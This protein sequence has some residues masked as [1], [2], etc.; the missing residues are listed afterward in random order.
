M[1]S[2][3]TIT[4]VFAKFLSA[5]FLSTLLISTPGYA[6]GGWVEYKNMDDFFSINLPGDVEPTTEEISYP[7]EYDA[8][9][10]GHVYSV[11]NE[12]G[13]YSVTVIDYTDAHNVHLARTNMTEAD[14]PSGYEYWRIDVLASISFAATNYRNKGGKVLYD[15]WHH[16]D[17]VP[18]HQ[19][20]IEN[21]D[22][23]RTYVSIYLHKNRLYIVD[24]TV[25][26]GSPPQ[27]HFQQSVGF[28]DET[29][30]NRLRYDWD[31][32][33]ALVRSR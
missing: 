14:E 19:L 24:A 10:P 16:I 18:G 32:N 30:G 1:H 29:T 22:G 2:I 9:F 23:S 6:Q 7:S 21:S 20:N 8:V 17:R 26:E 28:L 4:A 13:A 12:Q 25:P 15:A 3:K 33:G 5:L 27:G 31:E 11:N